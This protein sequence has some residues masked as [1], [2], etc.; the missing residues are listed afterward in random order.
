M[1]LVYRSK[2]NI[3]AILLNLYF[4]SGPEFSLG[5][6]NHFVAGFSRGCTF[7]LKSEVWRSKM[8][9]QDIQCLIC[10]KELEN[11]VGCK[12]CHKPFCKICIDKW[13]ED[14][15]SCPNCRANIAVDGLIKMEK[16]DIGFLR[17]LM[18]QQNDR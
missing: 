7:F 11:P 10:L 13:L 18:L 4:T 6:F 5:K 15:K 16:P 3:L 1:K 12:Y 9:N 14:A 2:K 8:E 17:Q